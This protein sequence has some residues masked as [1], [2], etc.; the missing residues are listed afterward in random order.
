M[1]DDLMTTEAK[2]EARAKAKS[3]ARALF[4]QGWRISHIATEVGIPR[5]TVQE[6]RMAEKWDD[7]MPLDRVQGA[8]EARLVQLIAKDGK[9]NGDY[10]EI[11]SLGRQ[12]ERMARVE[13]YKTTG[14]ESDLNPELNNRNAAAKRKPTINAFSEDQVKKL[15]DVFL[16]G[17][18]EYQRIWHN[19]R[20]LRTR[21][22]LKSRQIGATY[23]FSR[24][25]LID[26]IKTGN[27][28]I[29]LSASKA[30]A[31]VFK[32]YI[33]KFAQEADVELKGEN[34]TLWNG[35]QLIFLG[36]NSATAQSY[37]GDLY[38]D[39][40]FWV[41]KF[42]ELN[43]VASGMAMHKKWRKTY[44]STPSSITHE[45][46]E[47][48]SGARYNKNRSR[49][50]RI[51]ID[52][53]HSV[54]KNG[55]MGEDK[56]WRMITTVMDAQA[57][58][59]DL[60]DIDDLQ[61]EYSKDEFENLL[62]CQFTDDTQSV[63]PMAE[64]Q[65]C[66]VDSWEVWAHDYKPFTQRPYGYKPVWIGY[67]PN[68]GTMAGDGAAC[69]V[70]GPPEKQGGKFRI[71][72]KLQWKGLD[73]EAQAGE[74]EK[75]TRKYNVTAINIDTTGLGHAVLLNVLKFFPNAKAYD[76]SLE[77]KTALVLKAKS[78][79]SKGRVEFDA[80]WTDLA[81]HFMAIKEVLTPSGRSTT[82]SAGRSATTGHADLA[83]ACMHAFIEEGLD[84]NAHESSI[85]EIS[86]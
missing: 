35:A 26:A 50:Q 73:Y 81:A 11:D 12:I 36:T 69:A 84:N 52:L 28:K 7:A 66:M 46:Y 65:R 5:T 85:L 8:I 29:F 57:G 75:L 62:M 63:F 64:L 30:Q 83:F 19:N 3:A 49:D 33:K 21:F 27:N 67:D 6:W 54:L 43:K 42:A 47:M 45:A 13:R 76:Y 22:N 40:V 86:S 71:L 37:T 44:F 60:F 41:P 24:E 25:A 39:E 72:E 61:L 82:Y 56:V 18:F 51:Q 4:W 15:E 77:S 17:L 78:L 2:E 58:G 59:C 53:S 68:K 34:F 79:I 20:H 48:W 55:H 80:G 14:K 23:Y 10:K 9:S 70:V 31:Y 16:N 74:I 1:Q 32:N 38:F